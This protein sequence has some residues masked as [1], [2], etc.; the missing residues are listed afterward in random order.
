MARTRFASLTFILLLIPSFADATARAAGFDDSPPS[1]AGAGLEPP[2]SDPWS[3]PQ[4]RGRRGA[5]RAPRTTVL[6]DDAGHALRVQP[7][8]HFLSFEL[9]VQIPVAASRTDRHRRARIPIPG[10]LVDREGRLA[11]I[12][13]QF[14]RPHE[15]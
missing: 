7:R 8:R 6:E 3:S 4:E 14:G 10:R 5:R 2:L 15:G 9:P 1:A 11:D 13:N 12:G